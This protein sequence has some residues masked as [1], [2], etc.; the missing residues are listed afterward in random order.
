MQAHGLNRGSLARQ[1]KISPNIVYNFLKGRSHY[2]SQPTLERIAA[3]FGVPIGGILGEAEPLPSAAGLAENQT[4]VAGYKGAP[5]P[6]Q[7]L[8]LPIIGEIRSNGVWSTEIFLPGDS[9]EYVAFDIPALYAGKAFAVRVGGPSVNLLSAGD[10]ILGCVSARDYL[11]RLSAGDIVIMVRQN[12]LGLFETTV[13][14]YE[15]EGT[16]HFL[17]SRSTDNRFQERAELR[18]PLDK[19]LADGYQDF[20]IHAVVLHYSARLPAAR[21]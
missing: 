5:L 21:R 15:I 20:F 1:A 17:A 16:R 7:L 14:Q 8:P 2:L 4:V 12:S 11:Q 6:T 9:S 13:K 18:A 10:L 19:P 3:T